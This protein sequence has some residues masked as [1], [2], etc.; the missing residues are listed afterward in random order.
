MLGIN[1]HGASYGQV[2]NDHQ[3]S[4]PSLNSREDFILSYYHIS[5][6]LKLQMVH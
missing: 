2:F 3:N 4:S 6:Y 1:M 5:N